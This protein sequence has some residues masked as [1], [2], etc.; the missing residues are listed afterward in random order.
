[1]ILLKGGLG[2][3]LFQYSFFHLLKKNSLP[4]DG[5]LPYYQNDTYG[6]ALEI[7]KIIDDLRIYD[8]F[9]ANSKG[10]ASEN[11][12]TIKNVL[13]SETSNIIIQGY[14]QNF[15]YVKSSGVE[16]MI[17]TPTHTQEYTAL[18]LRRSDYGHH[19]LLPVKYYHQALT[20][21]GHPKFVIFTDEPN[22][23]LYYFKKIPGLMNI[24]PSDTANA[25]DDFLHLCSHRNIIMANSS[26]SWF[27]AYLAHAQRGANVIAP[28][29][30]SLKGPGPGYSRHWRIIETSLID[31]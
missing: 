18:H 5:F 29:K 17:K 13:I 11:F 9:P 21:L 26:Y 8:G 31:P 6:R 30:W 19:G 28:S 22:F 1:M 14:F 3:Q 10:F 12:E 16:N 20:Q 2:N 27:A 25:C 24:F 15:N 7:N 4:I 23:A